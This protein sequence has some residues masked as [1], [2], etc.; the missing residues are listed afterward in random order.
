MVMKPSKSSWGQ[1]G[2]FCRGQLYVPREVPTTLSSYLGAIAVFFYI[3][4]RV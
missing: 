1:Q 3:L 4:L 2:R